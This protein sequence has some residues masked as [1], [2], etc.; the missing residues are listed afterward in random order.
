MSSH[1]THSMTYAISSQ[2]ISDLN[3][4]LKSILKNK[5]EKNFEKMFLVGMN[6]Q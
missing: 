2:V 1:T 6:V 5:T 4:L 3:D